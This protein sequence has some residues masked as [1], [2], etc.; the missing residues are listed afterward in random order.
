MGG[1]QSSSPRS[2][3][4]KPGVGSAHSRCPLRQLPGDPCPGH[5]LILTL[6]ALCERVGQRKQLC[7]LITQLHP[8]GGTD[9]KVLPKHT[10]GAETRRV[11]RTVNRGPNLSRSQLGRGRGGGKAFQVEGW[12]VWRPGDQKGQAGFGYLVETQCDGVGKRAG[13]GKEVGGGAGA[14]ETG[15]A[16]F[17]SFRLC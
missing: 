13:V 9:S 4:A 3:K 5:A 1:Q 2:A 17:W 12:N 15:T 16:H 14:L 7:W 8:Q 6:P 11:Q 10:P